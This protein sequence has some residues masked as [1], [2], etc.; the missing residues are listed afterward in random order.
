MVTRPVTRKE[1]MS[2]PKAMEAFMKEWKGLWDQE[3]FVFTTTR[4]YDD[5]VA[6]AKKKGEEVHMARVHGLIYEKNYQLKQDDPA[7]K[8]KGRGVLLG[9]GP[10]HG[11]G[12][13]P[14]FGQFTSN[15]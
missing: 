7:R 10:E 12:A 8:F 1:M 3:V 11:S 13:V 15:V 5:V 6:E 4:E 14:G 9:Q 2:N